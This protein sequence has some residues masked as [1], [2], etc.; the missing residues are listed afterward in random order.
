MKVDE[1]LVRRIA[2]LARIRVSDEDVGHLKGE[3]SSILGFV[4]QLAEVD[5]ENVPPMTSS[6]ERAMRMRADEVTDGGYAEDIVKNAPVKDEH[7]F[8][9]PKVV[10]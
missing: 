7:Y 9:V 8:M 5:T 3:L 10:D 6:V 1:T 4:E 2:H